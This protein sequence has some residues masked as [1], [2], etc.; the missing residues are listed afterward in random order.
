MRY[1]S[2]QPSLVLIISLIS[3]NFIP[4]E[5]TPFNFFRSA[6]CIFGLCNVAWVRDKIVYDKVFAVLIYHRFL[7]KKYICIGSTAL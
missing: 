2:I 1:L 7:D 4:K 3:R 5:Q 6:T